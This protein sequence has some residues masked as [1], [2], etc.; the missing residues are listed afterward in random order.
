MIKIEKV[1]LDDLT[2][3]LFPYLKKEFGII[4]CFTTRY[5]GYSNGKFKSLNVDYYTDDS[6]IN[7]KR[8]REVILKKL[9]LDGVSKIYS[10]KQVHGNSILDISRDTNLND[11]NIPIEV[12]CLI[13]NL[14]KVPIMVMGADCNL[15]L[16]ADLRKKIIAAVHAGWKGTLQEITARAISYMIK[17]FKSKKRNIFVVFGPSIR[18]CCYKVNSII[19]D[20]FINKFGCRDFFTIKNNSFYL[21]LVSINYMQL[22]NS[23]ISDENISDCGECTCCNP[24]FYSYRR[25]KITGRQAAIAA[26]L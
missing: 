15:I 8:N 9:N 7:V 24:D 11:D 20:K 25:S 14:K 19:I 12:D 22:K 10:V 21:D 4:F 13:T 6:N 18:K 17:K 1:L 2:I 5:G 16:I 3:Y 26:I 23:G